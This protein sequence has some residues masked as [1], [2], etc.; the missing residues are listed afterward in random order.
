MNSVSRDYTMVSAS[1]YRSS[2]RFFNAPP[3]KGSIEHNRC[4]SLRLDP[5]VSG[6][7]WSVARGHTC[8]RCTDIDAIALLSVRSVFRAVPARNM[9]PQHPT[10]FNSIQQEPEMARSEYNPG[11]HDWRRVCR[12]GVHRA[13]PCQQCRRGSSTR[14]QSFHSRG[15]SMVLRRWGHNL[16]EVSCITADGLT[17]CS[18]PY[19]SRF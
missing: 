13:F 5:P 8:A 17:Q 11:A 12:S 19:A 10:P 18:P 3:K 1:Y 2:D 14:T 7:L 16:T 4:L 15:R 9:A 6:V